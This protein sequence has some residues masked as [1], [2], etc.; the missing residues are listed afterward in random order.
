[1]GGKNPVIVMDDADLAK[2][3]EGTARAA[4]GFSGQKCSAASRVY[5]HTAV[6]EEFLHRLVERSQQLSLGDP[7]KSDVFTG[8][9]ISDVAYARFQASCERARLDGE[10][11]LGGSVMDDGELAHGFFCELT[12]ARLPKDHP[13]FYD[14]LFI[15]LL[16]VAI[17]DSFDEA[18]VLAND[19]PFG[20]TAGLFSEN[21][22]TIDRFLDEIEAGV[23]Y[24]NRK[25][26][27]TTGA[28]PG[29]QSFGG[30]KMSG[31]TGKSA[32]GPYYVQ[33]FMHEQTQTVVSD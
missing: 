7:A 21:R 2:A 32:L 17:V 27:A 1:M 30:W 10:I 8:P 31:S 3:V 13:F 11:V 19:S 28:W 5:V 6:A 26:G 22:T 14:E 18:I 20:L 23:A 9:V 24:V 33:Q 25:S 12:I 4:F 29:V 16:A 15:P